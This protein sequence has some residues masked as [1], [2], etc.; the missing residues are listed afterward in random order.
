[1]MKK[2][3][4]YVQLM[5]PPR[6]MSIKIM[7]K[8]KFLQTF[9]A[10]TLLLVF[11]CFL[12][13]SCEENGG[14]EPAVQIS[15]DKTSIEL[16]P[17]GEPVEIIV[18]V[19]KSS[20]IKD[21]YRLEWDSDET[22]AKVTAKEPDY[23]TI[24]DDWAN[25]SKSTIITLNVEPIA[26][27]T[28]TIIIKFFNLISDNEDQDKRECTVNVTGGE[29]PR[30]TASPPAGGVIRGTTITLTATT[31][32]AVIYYTTDGSNPTKDSTK[33]SSS[34]PITIIADTTIKAIAVKEDMVDSD[35][36]IAAYTI[37]PVAI[38]SAMPPAGPVPRYSTVTLSTTPEDSVI[39]YTTDGSTPTTSSNVFSDTSSIIITSSP[40]TIKAFAVKGSETS[41]ML[42][43]VYTI[44]Q[45][46]KPTA[47][48]QA[49]EVS[50]GAT[51]TLTTETEGAT[52]YYT[53]GG[54]DPT[55]SSIKYTGPIPITTG[56]TIK[57]IAGKAGIDDSEILEAEYTIIE[58]E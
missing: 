8:Q 9:G 45:A 29:L 30:P 40:T 51:V 2:I 46:A 4:V 57:A 1:M 53:T 11:A 12:T 41:G 25:I 42:T 27:G 3:I 39:Y 34:T 52:I 21:L 37:I 14:Y 54:S 18:T 43:A 20:R 28:T 15:L 19:V 24:F 16:K 10:L 58:N 6:V 13:V 17:A 44:S 31:Q 47:N 50:I 48:P 7:N 56:I 49:G 22:V 33:Y 55:W 35:I 26:P 36:L 23:E 38:P 32:G 5:Y